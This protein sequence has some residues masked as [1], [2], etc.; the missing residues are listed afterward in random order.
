MHCLTLGS[1]QAFNKHLIF[2]G[3]GAPRMPGVWWVA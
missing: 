2:D 3:S 1:R